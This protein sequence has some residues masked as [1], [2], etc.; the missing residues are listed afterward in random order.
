MSQRAKA[1]R[2]SNAAKSRYYTPGPLIQADT[3]QVTELDW[4]R[5]KDLTEADYAHLAWQ[6][7]HKT[8]VMDRFMRQTGKKSSMSFH[9]LPQERWDSIFGKRQTA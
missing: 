3:K 5:R 7:Q 6:D 8:A 9:R 4:D 1:I 2:K